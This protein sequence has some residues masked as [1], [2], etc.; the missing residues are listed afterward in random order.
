MDIKDLIRTARRRLDLSQEELGELV[1]VHEKTV[2]KWERGIA[3]PRGTKLAQLEK[4]LGIRLTNRPEDV[5]RVRVA[6][7]AD[8]TNAE[9]SGALLSY[10]AEL[11][12]RLP[13]DDLD[14]PLDSATVLREGWSATRASDLTDEGD[15]T[16]GL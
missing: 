10:L 16:T 5:R 15:G 13:A 11:A 6:E 3:A 14:G 2:G 9:L 7:P 4:H 8:L 1:G 12:R